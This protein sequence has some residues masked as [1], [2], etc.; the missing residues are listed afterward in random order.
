MNN[1]ILIYVHLLSLLLL[2]TAPLEAKA[3]LMDPPEARCQESFLADLDADGNIDLTPE[4]LNDGSTDDIPPA[5]E[6]VLSLDFGGL[7]LDCA[8][9][10][11]PAQ[12]VTLIVTDGD[13]FSSSC[14]SPVTVE[15]NLAPVVT[16]QNVAVELP[17]SG[18]LGLS[19]N[20]FRD[21]ILTDFDDN[22]ATAPASASISGGST[23]VCDQLGVVTRTFIYRDG[24]GQEDRCSGVRLQVN[25]PLGVCGEDPIANCSETT[26][27]VDNLE[28]GP[29]VVNANDLD[30]GSTDDRSVYT[31]VYSNATDRQENTTFD[32]S[33]TGPNQGQTFIAGQTGVIQSIKVRAG[34]NNN[35]TLTIRNGGVLAGTAGQYTQEVNLF[36]GQYS[37]RAN[38]TVINLDVPFPVVA[39]QEYS[40]TFNCETTLSRSCAGSAAYA[41]GRPLL[42][43]GAFSDSGDEDLTFEVNIIGPT[44]QAFDSL[45]LNPVTVFAVDDQGN[46][47]DGCETFVE[48][49]QRGPIARCSTT[50]V[51]QLDANGEIVLEPEDLDSLSSLDIAGALTFTFGSSLDDLDCEAAR[52]GTIHPVTLVVT[53]DFGTSDSCVSL[54]SVRDTVPPVLVCQD[55]VIPI[56]PETGTAIYTTAAAVTTI[57]DNCGG[58]LL[59]FD[60]SGTNVFTCG[61]IGRSITRTLSAPDQSSNVSTCEINL[62]ITDPEDFC[63]AFIPPMAVC[64]PTLSVELDEDGNTNLS[65]AEL[66]NGSTDLTTPTEDLIFSFDPAE[67]LLYCGDIGTQAVSLIVTDNV[68]QADTCFTQ[69]TVEDNIALEVICQDVIFELRSNSRYVLVLDDILNSILVDFDDNCAELNTESVAVSGGTNFAC[70]A[71]GEITKSFTFEDDNGEESECDVTLAITDPL[72]VCGEDPVVICQPFTVTD[73][74]EPTVNLNANVFDDGSTDD[75]SVYALVY[76]DMTDRQENTTFDCSTTSI[77]QGQIFTAGQTGV[78]QSIKVR[79]GAATSNRLLIRDSFFPGDT[80]PFGGYTQNVDLFFGEHSDRANLTVMTLDVPFPVEA[81]QLYFFELQGETTLSRSCPGSDAYADG[82]PTQGFGFFSASGDEDLTFEVNIIG[83]NEMEFASEGGTPVTVYAV[84]DQ[85]NASEGCNTFVNPDQPFPVSW[86]SFGAHAGA[87]TVELQWETTEEPDNAGFHAERS[88]TGNDWSVIGQVEA[89]LGS[90][91]RY[92]FID[93]SPLNGISYYRLRQT[94]FDGQVTY[95]PVNAVEFLANDG[96]V[97]YPN[98]A[99]NE[100]N[101]Q[102]PDGAE[103]L[104]LMNMTGQATGLR[105][106]GQNS[107]VN[108]DVSGLPAGVYFLHVRL[109]DGKPLARRLVVR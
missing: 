68:G 17:A 40:F 11:D 74:T 101:I 24:N 80:V 89:L 48:V 37:G 102:L 85:G 25:D 26:V 70:G 13:G 65:P 35:T 86:L 57:A 72:G 107:Q 69:V 50:L 88:A 100:V 106:N 67:G 14:T 45:G 47:S 20:L 18:N 109:A 71:I 59:V 10:G 34:A 104:G 63:L 55:V 53:N 92:D 97:L 76:S 83:P 51:A 49:N 99:T 56:N 54:V 91:Q 30:N 77:N 87:K 103:L 61:D 78:I 12:P 3:P 105:F 66:D 46:V 41:G 21:V 2:F 39:G 73:A 96:V 23:L 43:F 82:R 27:I 64:H 75:R 9:I 58:L 94:D 90:D 4:D 42:D 28:D 36:F 44:T 95:S 5:N 15:D 93:S 81:G 52:L 33:T 79:A 60:F 29:A 16:C 62:T 8:A 19:L 31:L 32:C 7:V 6:L 38:L 22:C 1:L 84:D 98:P 108:A